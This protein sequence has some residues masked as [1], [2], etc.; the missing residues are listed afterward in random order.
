MPLLVAGGMLLGTA[1]VLDAVFRGRLAAQGHWLPLI[2]GGAFN[3]AEYHRLRAEKGWA[4]WPVYLMWALYVCGIGLL[5][6]GWFVQSGTQ[7][8]S[9]K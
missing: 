4:A 7:P 5:I 2:K 1:L 9:T 3:Y 8:V 6:A